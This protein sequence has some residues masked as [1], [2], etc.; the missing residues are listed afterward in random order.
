MPEPLEIRHKIP[1]DEKVKDLYQ[2]LI[3]SGH[4]DDHELGGAQFKFLSG[5]ADS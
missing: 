4:F 1:T 5:I 2:M 3:S